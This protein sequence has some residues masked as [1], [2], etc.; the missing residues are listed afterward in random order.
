LEVKPKAKGL[1]TRKELLK[2]YDENYSANLM[3]LVIYTNGNI[4]FVYNM[5]V[6][7]FFIFFEWQQSNYLCM[8]IF[9]NP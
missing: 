6:E 5:S 9:R 2:F 3:H 1:D 4:Y 8:D 7:L